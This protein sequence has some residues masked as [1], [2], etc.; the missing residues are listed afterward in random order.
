MR[1]SWIFVSSVFLVGLLWL[2]SIPAAQ[3]QDKIN[4]AISVYLKGEKELKAGKYRDAASSF[5]Q[6]HNLVPRIPRFNCHRAR[7]LQYKANAEEKMRSFYAAI[8]TYHTAAYKTGCGDAK[9]KGDA[10]R[11][12]TTLYRRWMSSIEFETTPPKAK[13][14]EIAANGSEKQIGVTP[15]RLY[16][17][18]GSFKYKLRLYEYQTVFLNVKLNAGNHIKRPFKLVKGDDPI[19]RPEAVDIAPPPPMDMGA[20]TPEGSPSEA[21]TTPQ[22]AEGSKEEPPPEGEGESKIKLDPEPAAEGGKPGERV[23]SLGTPTADEL[24]LDKRRNV[25]KPGPPIYRQAW[26]WITISA[27]VVGA[28]IVA[29][30]VPK[31]QQV[32]VTQGSVF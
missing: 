15:M 22:P 17:L 27:V 11:K 9:I 5:G 18:P 26:F 6:A 16:L 28:V 7:F 25:V 3:A 19:N 4:K 24:S 8:R 23:A 21:P 12:Y 14:I 31:E 10:G 30:V 2:G 20:G 1:R 29:I 32:T 13:I